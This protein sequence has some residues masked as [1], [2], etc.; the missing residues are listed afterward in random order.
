MSS[1]PLPSAEKAPEASAFSSPVPK[2]GPAAEALRRFVRMVALS[3][4][5]ERRARFSDGLEEMA[6]DA[7]FSAAFGSGEMGDDETGEPWDVRAVFRASTPPSPHVRAVVGGL[8]ADAVVEVDLAG[9]VE[10]ASRA[11]TALCWLAA[12]TW[13]DA[14]ADVNARLAEAMRTEGPDAEARRARWTEGLE[15]VIAHTEA[16]GAARGRGA[17]LAAA[18][19]LTAGSAR[20]GDASSDPSPGSAAAAPMGGERNGAAAAVEGELVPL[21]L[22]PVWLALACATGVILLRWAWRFVTRGLLRTRRPATATLEPQGVRVKSDWVLLGRRLQRA[23]VVIPFDQLARA[24]REIR[25]PRLAVYAG[26]MALATGT[27]I[28]ASLVTDGVRAGSP[29][30]LAIGAGVF[31]LGV[32]IDV[33]LT[34]VVPARRE[35]HRLLLVPRKGRALALSTDPN[36]AADGLLRQLAARVGA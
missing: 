25:H 3:A 1:N 5:D 15:E 23:D 19:A 4:A 20:A 11:T 14:R 2:S 27:F 29:S 26:L 22:H 32:A 8:L 9:D 6:N 16:I 12:E 24:E 13:L 31:A 30:M 28:G 18:A 36:G 10:A 21:R 7:E 33:L 17:A 35:K 34:V